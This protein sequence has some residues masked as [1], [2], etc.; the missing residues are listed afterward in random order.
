[1]LAQE[2][3]ITRDDQRLQ[4]TSL[5]NIRGKRTDV[6]RLRVHRPVERRILGGRANRRKWDLSDFA[7]GV[8]GI[9]LLSG[10][11]GPLGAALDLGGLHVM[12]GILPV[13]M[14][15]SWQRTYR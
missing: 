14:T 6:R 5:G 1:M 4:D 11:E 3:A 13:V 9:W 12:H 8:H 7:M 15:V 10:W 2:I